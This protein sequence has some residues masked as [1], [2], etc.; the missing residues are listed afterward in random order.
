MKRIPIYRVPR[1]ISLSSFRMQHEE[2][3]GK[4]CSPQGNTSIDV[5]SR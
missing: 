5:L 1:Y 2:N 4:H 3:H